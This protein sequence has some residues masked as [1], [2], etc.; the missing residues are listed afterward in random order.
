VESTTIVRRAATNLST[1]LANETVLLAL[2]SGVY[3]GMNEVGSRVW[4]LLTEPRSIATICQTIEV[5]FEVSQEVCERDVLKFL[6]DLQREG[7]VVS[8]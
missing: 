4:E 6:Q 8:A 3:F 1:A 2:E 5:E 7:L